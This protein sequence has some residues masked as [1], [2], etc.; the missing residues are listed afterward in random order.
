MITFSR[1]SKKTLGKRLACLP[2][3]RGDTYISVCG[4]YFY[5]MTESGNCVA[6]D[7]NTGS[8]TLVTIYAVTLDVIP[9]D[10]EV[11]ILA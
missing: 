6:F 11:K 4:R 9:C 5:L 3:R 2:C 7:I 10:I 8:M 1:D